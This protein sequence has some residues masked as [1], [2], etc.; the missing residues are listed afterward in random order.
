MTRLD[1]LEKNG[2]GGGGTGT[3]GK[4]GREVELQNSG[5]AIQWRYTGEQDWKDLIQISELKGSN[6]I[7]PAV[8]ENGNWFL[9]EEDTGKPSRGEN[10]KGVPSGGTTGQVLTKRSNSDYD[11]EWRNPSSEGGG[12]IPDI[13]QIRDR[14]YLIEIDDTKEL[15]IAD[16]R[17]EILQTVK[18]GKYKFLNI[19]DGIKHWNAPQQKYDYPKKLTMEY[20]RNSEFYANMWLPNEMNCHDSLR[21]KVNTNGT[22]K[23][24]DVNDKADLVAMLQWGILML[25]EGKEYPSETVH[26]NVSNFKTLGFNRTS[27]NWELIHNAYPTGAMFNIEGTVADED[28][29]DITGVDLKNGFYSFEISQDKWHNSDGNPMCFHFFP[30]SGIS[31]DTLNPYENLI[32]AFDISIQEAKYDSTFVVMAGADT[33][34]SSVELE[35]AF[36]SRFRSVRAY[37]KSINVTSVLESES[38]KYVFSTDRIYHLLNCDVQ[39]SD[40]GGGGGGEYTE[41]SYITLD[42]KCYFDTEIVPDIQTNFE[43][44]CNPDKF[45]LSGSYVCGVNDGSY[46]YGLTGTDN[47]Y[48][49]RG[50]SSSAAKTS[51]WY[52]Q[53]WKV[54]QEGTKVLFNE[55]EITLDE[56]SVLS[57]SGNFFVGNM[58]DGSGSTK[59]EN[60]LSGKLYYVKLYSG[61]DLI[62]D[63]IPVKKNDGTLCLYDKVSKKYLLNKGTGTVKQ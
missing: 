60:G 47:W 42:G 45:E 37:A 16:N 36:Y 20:I 57:P 1:E 50:S 18:D 44:K 41:L 34:G 26:F 51:P 8:G 49:V 29:V 30:K 48:V 56:A 43:I 17:E 33:Y 46:K 32:V 24:D 11:T 61:S 63:A 23:Y 4:D 6:G 21:Y 9:G 14:T 12:D 55:T 40:G 10:G 52:T 28:T 35:E 38:Y 7:T 58:S 3:P 13:S 15:T 39:I 27:R 5:T 62:L 2:G 31:A 53:D 19:P 22:I 54:K 25:G 59:G